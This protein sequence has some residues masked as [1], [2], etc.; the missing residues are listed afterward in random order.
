MVC[1]S[2]SPAPRRRWHRQFLALLPQIVTHAKY[3][4][5][6]LNPELRAEMVQEVV[7]NAMQAFVRL[8]KLGK[9]DLAYATPLAIYGCRQAR[10][11]RKV[12]GHLNCLDVSSSYCQRLKGIVVDRLDQFDQEENAWQ[13]VLIEDK[14]AD[15]S[16]IVQTK[17]DMS[18]WLA[19]LKRRDRR[20]AEFLALGNR[21]SEAA[22]KFKVSEGRVS[23]L[24][25]ELAKSWSDF[26]AGNKGNAA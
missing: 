15:A 6:H 1:A 25:R 24:R 20:I 9:T 21:T 8:A 17:M 13:E 2:P 10:D 23:Q 16:Q 12:G 22:H 19:S 18:D 26:I 11:G 5:R 7:C 3:A 14:H 4:F